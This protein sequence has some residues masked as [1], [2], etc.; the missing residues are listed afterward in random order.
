[1]KSNK[2]TN[3]CFVF[4]KGAANF[5]QF[6]DDDQLEEKTDLDV[7]ID[8]ESVLVLKQNKCPTHPLSLTW[9]AASS[10]P[11]PVSGGLDDKVQDC[12]QAVAWDPSPLDVV[13]ETAGYKSRQLGSNLKSPTSKMLPSSAGIPPMSDDLSWHG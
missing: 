10:W 4:G 8:Q 9:R 7:S 12:L 2:N 3:S 6:Q 11:G 5:K 1:M 13:H